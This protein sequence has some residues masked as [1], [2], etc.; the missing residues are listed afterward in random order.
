MNNYLFPP[1]MPSKQDGFVVN[2]E[3]RVYFNL[4]PLNSIDQVEHL[5]LSLYRQDNNRNLLTDRTYTSSGVSLNTRNSVLYYKKSEIK[6]SASKQM[7]YVVIPKLKTPLI[8]AG[9][10]AK[11]Q[12][13]LGTQTLRFANGAVYDNSTG[14]EMTEVWNNTQINVLGMSEWSTISIIKT[15]SPF[16]SYIQNFNKGVVNNINTTVYTFVGMTNLYNSNPKETIKSTRFVLFDFRGNQ[17]EDSGEIIQPESQKLYNYH[18]FNKVL[19]PDTTYQ[20]LFE[21]STSSGYTQSQLYDFA[22]VLEDRVITYSIELNES[23]YGMSS[24]EISLT[25]TMV[26]LVVKDAAYS[27]ENLKPNT[28]LI[29]RASSKDNFE[30]WIDLAEL[31]CA[32]GTSELY[33]TY[34]DIMVES[35]ITY[36]YTV[37][38]K[39]LNSSRL[40]VSDSVEATPVYEH[41]WLLGQNNAYL[42]I[43]FN[44]NL[45]NFKTVIK[46]AK[47]ETI[48]SQY[49]FFVRNGDIKYREFS[50]SGLICQNMDAMNSLRIGE[51]ENRHIQER[52]FRDSLHELLLDGKPKLFKSETEGLILVYLSNVSLTPNNVLGRMLYDFSMTATEIGRVDVDN[53]S[54][55][56]IIQFLQPGRDIRMPAIVGYVNEYREMVSVDQAIT[57]VY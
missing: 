8:P 22:V 35:G 33:A 15:L 57:G 40:V 30:T 55:A 29:R 54:E 38:P 45:S 17:L 56:E 23:Y 1:Y 20:V 53:L 49:P 46:E 4:S 18:T 42:S 48:G 16:D 37:Q 27:D 31:R 3:G 32:I 21:V 19:D 28:Y 34:N 14:E 43:G 26:R 2:G 41:T 51:Y 36:K 52:M 25:K 13:R 7:Y 9:L 44:L 50:L 12:I 10:V 5:Q 47:I 11:I 24:E 39:M 6:F